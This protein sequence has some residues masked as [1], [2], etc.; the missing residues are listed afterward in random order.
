[1]EIFGRSSMFLQTNHDL[2]TDSFSWETSAHMS[3][4][5]FD[6]IHATWPELKMYVAVVNRPDAK[7]LAHRQMDMRLLSS[8]LLVGLTCVV[9]TQG[10]RPDVPCRSDWPKLSQALAAGGNVRSLRLQSLP[11]DTGLGLDGIKLVPDTEP[12]KLPRLDLAGLRL[13]QLEEL[14][15]ESLQH[16][17]GSTYFWDMDYARMFRM[18]I[19]C[20]RLRKLDFG[21]DNPTA[22]FTSFTGLCPKLKTLSFGMT[23]NNADTEPAKRFIASLDALE[24]LDV[25]QAQQ[26]IDDLWPAIEKHKDT[27]QTLVLGPT[28]GSYCSPIYMDSNLLETIALTFPKLERLGWD[29]PCTTD[30][31]PTH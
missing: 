7:I 17:G 29:A 2:L 26:G 30:V 22:F 21:S 15:I 16:W 28:L 9:Y 11:D 25:S 1:M 23:V 20:S 12:E 10:Y 24:H 6:M 5:V 19:D 18:S 13:P 4:A 8:P 31:S 3:D 27:L 14:T